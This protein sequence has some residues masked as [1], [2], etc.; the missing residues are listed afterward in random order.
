MGIFK[1]Y[2]IRG[3]YNR[4]FKREDVYRIGYFLPKLLKTDKVLVGHDC[5]I[6]S[7][8]IFEYLCEGIN[9]SGADVYYTGY[10]TTPMIYFGT[11]SREF[12]ASV[13]ITASHNPKEYN[14]LKISRTGALPVGYD[15]GL[16]ELE[17]MVK[18]GKIEKAAKKGRLV[19]CQLKDD[20]IKFLK[21]YV[22]DI[23]NLSIAVDCSNGMASILIKDILG[24]MPY[25]IY[26][27]MDG[28]FPNHEPNPLNEN[29]VRDL[30]KLVLRNGC[31]LGVIYDGD[32]DRVIFVDEKGKFIPPDLIIGAIGK[33]YL[34]K[35]KGNVLHDIRTSRA[36]SEY[37]KTLGGTPYMWKV[38]HAFAKVKL[39]EIK[40]IFGGELAGHYYFRDFFNCDSGIFASL[41]VLDV[42]SRI[43]KEG[44]T[45]SS[46]IDSIRV[47][48]NSGEINFKLDKK[49]EAM[50]A[51]KDETTSREE[52]TAFYDF[53]GYR[54][55][56]KDWWFNVRSSNTEPYLRLVVEA[57]D[58]KMLHEKL[59]ELKKI[60]A[61]YMN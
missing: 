21:Q 52:P 25:Y 44:M 10:S 31:D 12:D 58:R 17:Q 39:R 28:T 26:D 6:S 61:R 59:G 45:F 55:E 23:S 40:G 46:L 9:D 20:Y 14:G 22:P 4:D 13:Q 60:I 15:T 19:N 1:A 56:F 57:A 2:D 29:N 24:I 37:I 27:T 11:A 42:V 50:D 16:A 54:I 35:E 32:G 36:V 38:G 34:E 8:E 3:I 5:R 18:N 47:Y 7:G 49:K 41:I 30:E 48:A 33:Y 53:D 43:K 51:L